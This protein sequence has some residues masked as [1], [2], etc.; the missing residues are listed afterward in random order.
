M[1][2]NRGCGPQFI[3]DKKEHF[4]IEAKSVMKKILGREEI[5]QM[6]ERLELKVTANQS[7]PFFDVSELA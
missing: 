5:S 3:V 7:I 4:K 2:S 6:Q 1:K